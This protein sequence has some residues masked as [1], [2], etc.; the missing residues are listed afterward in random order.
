[1]LTVMQRGN[2]DG[3]MLREE[4]VMVME[5]MRIENPRYSKKTVFVIVVMLCDE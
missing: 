4:E 3:W 2:E 5:E 1:M